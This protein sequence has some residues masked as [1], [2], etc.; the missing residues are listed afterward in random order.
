MEPQVLSTTQHIEYLSLSSPHLPA[1]LLD[2]SMP[3]STSRSSAF[4]QRHYWENMRFH[5]EYSR[6][7]RYIHHSFD[8]TILFFSCLT[9]HTIL[10]HFPFICRSFYRN[11]ISTTFGS[12][13]FSPSISLHG[14]TSNR[15]NGQADDRL[16]LASA[17]IQAPEPRFAV[18]SDRNAGMFPFVM[19][20]DPGVANEY[21]PD[22]TMEHSDRFHSHPQFG[23]SAPAHGFSTSSYLS[24]CR[25]RL[26]NFDS[27]GL[28]GHGRP[29]PSISSMTSIWF[30]K[31]RAIVCT[32]SHHH[33]LSS[34]VE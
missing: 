15:L 30:P 25:F 1:L 10:I 7:L 28:F 23:V 4:P 3:L 11:Q 13:L 22:A 26:L 5:S 12:L 2:S 8:E 20:D 14:T 18:S 16:R 17:N 21:P 6:T 32:D 31:I 34:D 27:I 19:A 29:C 33:D 9:H 24:P